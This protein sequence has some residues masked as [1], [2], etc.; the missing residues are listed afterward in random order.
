MRYRLNAAAA[1][2]LAASVTPAAAQFLP[3]GPT[4]NWT[5]PYAGVA[6]GA[7]WGKLHGN[8]AVAGTPAG[9]APGSPAIPGSVFGLHNNSDA[10][11]TGGGQIGYNYQFPN[12]I[13]I[14][15]EGDIRGGGPSSTTRVGTVTGLANF[16]PGDRFH[17]DSD[18]NAS[19]RGKL[20][21]AWGPAL[22]YATGGVGFAN[23]NMT[24]NYAPSTVGGVSV[25]GRTVS[26]SAL[27][28]GPTVGGGVEY[29]VNP[30][31]S[32][33]GEYRYSDYGTETF[34]IGPLATAAGTGGALA[35]AAVHGHVGL[36]DNTFMLKVNYRF[37]A[38]PPPPLPVAAPAPPPP[39]APRVFIVFFDWDKDV[40]TPQGMQVVQ[41]AADAYK[42][43]APVQIQVTGYTDRSGSPGYNQRLS[44]RRANNVAKAMQGLGVPREQMIVSG[45][46]E[47]DNRVPTANG[48]REPQNRRVEITAP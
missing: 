31:I 20:G 38:P 14:G 24:A 28:I 40:V 17:T 4:V 25:P 42:S 7:D 6:L 2:A 45:R 13:V 26:D 47:N 23:A 34:H 9:A 3:S 43:G 39:P 33:A 10:T 29:A 11:V 21:Y 35:S 8:V 46:G 12:N 22:I 1:M 16:V 30:N 41:Q 15:A 44:E 27:L 36:Q 32:V 37:G 18:F 5:G 48:V 19:I